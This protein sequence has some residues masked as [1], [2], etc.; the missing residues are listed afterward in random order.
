MFLYFF[1]LLKLLAKWIKRYTFV[2]L[3][4]TIVPSEAVIVRLT[5][6]EYAQPRWPTSPTFTFFKINTYL[7][8]ISTNSNTKIITSKPCAEIDN[9][10]DK[11]SNL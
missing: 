10:Y 8:I 2:L 1:K 11:L 9:I 6:S 7:Y 5:W 3:K 4:L